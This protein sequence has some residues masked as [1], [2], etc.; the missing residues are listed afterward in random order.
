MPS[1]SQSEAPR[2]RFGGPPLARAI[3]RLAA[4]FL[5]VVTLRAATASADEVSVPIE[6]QVALLDRVLR[7]EATFASE[8]APVQILVVTRAGSPESTRVT[9]QLVAELMRAGRLGGRALRA[10]PITY[11]NATSLRS[12]VSASHARIIYL[13]AGLADVVGAIRSAEAGT[14]VITVSAVGAYVDHGALIGFELRSSRPR[15]VINL[16]ESRSQGFRFD[17]RFLRL[18]RVVE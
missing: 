17:P 12:E 7:Y 6:L 14:G 2:P 15:I 16:G 5:L 9:A 13:S 3:P 10:A 1:A 18:A 4:L 8:T 11:S